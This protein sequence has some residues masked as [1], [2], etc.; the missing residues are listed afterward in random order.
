MNQ[1]KEG[2]SLIGKNI[3]WGQVSSS[4]LT[5]WGLKVQDIMAETNDDTDTNKNSKPEVE[6]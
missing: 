2:P 5:G 1:S 6:G 4:T 3:A